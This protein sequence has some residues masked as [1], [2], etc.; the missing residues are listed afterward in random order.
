MVPASVVSRASAI[1]PP[2]ANRCA[3][4]EEVAPEIPASIRSSEIIGRWGY[5]SF[6][7][8]QDRARAEVS[9]KGQCA[10]PFV[11]GQGSTGGV[12]MYAPDQ[13]QMQEL[14]LKGAPAASITS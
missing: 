10:H 8:P 12:M 7:R 6:H 4:A 13:T 5:A 3:R 9:A 2:T 14:W 11:I 1:R